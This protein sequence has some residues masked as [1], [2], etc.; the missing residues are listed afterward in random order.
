MSPTPV[1]TVRPDTGARRAWWLGGAL[2]LLTGVLALASLAVGSTG[3]EPIVQVGSQ[4]AQLMAQ[5][6]SAVPGNAFAGGDVGEQAISAQIL[7]DIRAPRTLGA[8]LA[9]ALLGLAG[10]V[11]QGL[12]RNPL[13]DPI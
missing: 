5:M 7:W 4:L 8:F 12:F 13:A 11:A 1:S 6:V 2:V 9:G 3:M 10:A